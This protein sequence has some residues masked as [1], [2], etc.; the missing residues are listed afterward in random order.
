MEAGISPTSVP[1]AELCER[2]RRL[3]MPAVCDA[4]YE[5][6]LPELV[7]PTHLRPLLPEQRMVGVAYTVEGRDIRP[8]V[9]WDEGIGRMQSYL[10]MFEELPAESVLVSATPDGRV[11]HFGELTANAARARGCVGC[12]LEGNL[13]DI[14]GLRNI[15]FQVFY[16]DLSP[17]NGIGRWEMVTS[18]EPVTIGDVT[19]RT[20]DVVFGE[21]DGILVIPAEHAVDVLVKAEEVVSAEG[22][23]RDEVRDGT[24]PWA[25]FERHG[26]I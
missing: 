17:L 3:Y 4:A 21:F 19:V 11:G 9:S 25:S 10:R 1:T 2:Y 20:G 24:A 14:A 12:V 23:V 22:S 18:R 7:L 26:H 13:R 15:G 6:G 8:P 5:L 16:R